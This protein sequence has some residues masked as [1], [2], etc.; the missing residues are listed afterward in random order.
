MHADERI[1][2]SKSA[3]EWLCKEREQLTRDHVRAFMSTELDASQLDTMSRGE[4]LAIHVR[5]FFD[6]AVAARVAGSLRAEHRELW[7]LGPY[8][9]DMSYLYGVPMQV[10]GKSAAS[11]AAY[12]D[13][14]VPTMRR[15]RALFAPNPSPIDK[16]RLEL[17]E[18]WPAGAM[19]HHDGG[20]KRI[21]GLL[22]A[23]RCEDLI[24]G[25]AAVDGACHI[26]DEGMGPRQCSALLYLQ[27]PDTGGELSIWNIK[28]DPRNAKNGLFA[29][30]AKK[31]FVQGAQ[32]I[33]HE[34]LGPP[35][36][37][38]RGQPGD[39]VIFDTA[40]PHAVRG[41][42]TGSRLAIQTFVEMAQPKEPLL[43]SS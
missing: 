23:M 33:I 4:A 43:L 42:A 27:V 18:L 12:Y 19:I 2:V 17:D 32:E 21:A 35:S 34:V 30:I 9:T 7:H 8:R 29:L 20:C 40:R 38:I 24:E 41:F 6:P 10:A 31:A 3:Y 22:R 25:R 28:P 26:D 11:L 5:S 36:H 37:V 13:D 16:L 1:E 39:L 14:A 15:I